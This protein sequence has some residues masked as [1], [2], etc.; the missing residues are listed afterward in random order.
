MSQFYDWDAS[1]TAVD[2][3][4]AVSSGADDTSDALSLDAKAAAEVSVKAVY[5]AG[6]PT[7][8]LKVY[9]L[10]DTDG[11]TY[12]GEADLPWGFEMPYSGGGTYRRSFSVDPSRLG[13]FKIL[14]TNDSGVQVTVT[15][16]VRYAVI[17][18]S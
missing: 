18:S 16:K 10:R 2:T 15:T 13:G 5:A 3:D 7:Q 1:W 12:E 17:G 14:V 11:T 9:L 8:G 4:L 6:S